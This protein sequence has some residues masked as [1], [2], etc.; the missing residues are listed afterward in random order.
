MKRTPKLVRFS[1]DKKETKGEMWENE[2]MKKRENEVEKSGKWEK[3]AKKEKMWKSGEK[4][5]M[6]LVEMKVKE[7]PKGVKLSRATTTGLENSQTKLMNGL[8]GENRKS[9]LEILSY[10]DEILNSI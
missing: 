10:T 7:C 9:N 4:G 2:K 6:K 8:K 3:L 5:E 1:A